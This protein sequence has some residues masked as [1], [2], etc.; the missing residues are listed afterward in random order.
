ME[1][2][3]NETHR[4]KCKKSNLWLI[5]KFKML[6]QKLK[7][8]IEGENIIYSLNC[9]YG[10]HRQNFFMLMTHQPKN[11]KNLSQRKS[12]SEKVIWKSYFKRRKEKE[13]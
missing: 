9:V 4:K 11:N 13:T 7:K 12:K 6:S 2:F 5:H 1:T 8:E 3:E 10:L